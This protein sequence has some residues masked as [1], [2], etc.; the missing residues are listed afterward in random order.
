MREKWYGDQR[1]LAKWAT[2]L[3]LARE[4]NIKRVVQVTCLMPDGY[5]GTKDDHAIL[6]EEFGSDVADIV[7][8]HFR[9][10]EGVVELGR[11]VDVEVV[12]LPDTYPSETNNRDGYFRSVVKNWLSP[13]HDPTI[14][15]LDPDT[16]LGTDRTHVSP[17]QLQTIKGAMKG[18]DVL[19]FY[20]HEPRFDRGDW[21]VDRHVDF[22]EALDVSTDAVTRRY[23]DVVN[24][25]RKGEHSSAEKV[26]T[27][28]LS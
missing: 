20:Q 26:N 5:K 13:P 18:G 17:R 4:D 12:V 9:N 1:D 21:K 22:A 3:R 19:V 24:D 14:V 7:W 25:G 6:A 27:G 10:L 15:F 8:R 11:R 16:G 28:T 2:L 23:C